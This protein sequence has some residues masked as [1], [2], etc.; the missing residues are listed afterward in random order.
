MANEAP[1][2]I[3]WEFQV[4]SGLKSKFEEV[5]GP[6]GEWVRFFRQGDGYLGTEL[7]RDV[8]SPSRYVTI[9]NWVSQA[10]YDL[11]REAHLVEYQR[12]DAQCEALTER[13]THLGSFHRV[14]RSRRS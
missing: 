5:Y 11:F 2:A 14:G 8:K 12:L 7:H 3:V 6:D 13:E 1:Y 10:A 9:D 4:R